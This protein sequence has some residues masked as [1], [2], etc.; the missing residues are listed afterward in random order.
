ML[1]I[2]GQDIWTALISDPSTEDVPAMHILE[3]YVVAMPEVLRTLL[4]EKVTLGTLM[5]AK[6][7]FTR[8][9][10][11]EKLATKQVMLIPPALLQGRDPVQIATAAEKAM[12]MLCQILEK[13]EVQLPDLLKAAGMT[14]ETYFSSPKGL[15]MKSDV[16]KSYQAGTLTIAELLLQQPYLIIKNK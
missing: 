8:Y 13:T 6:I 15:Q 12:E 11:T 10:S 3:P 16:Y 5:K 9:L 2:S 7:L 4:E 1:K 14:E